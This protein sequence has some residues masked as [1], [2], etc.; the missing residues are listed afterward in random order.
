MANILSA[1]RIGVQL[2]GGS[3]YRRTRVSLQISVG[4]VLTGKLGGLIGMFVA[5]PPL[6]F[7]VLFAAALNP[8]PLIVGW[9]NTKKIILQNFAPVIVG[10]TKHQKQLMKEFDVEIDEIKRL[11]ATF[12]DKLVAE[13][14]TEMGTEAYNFQLDDHEISHAFEHWLEEADLT[15]LNDPAQKEKLKELLAKKIGI[16]PDDAHYLKVLEDS[17][18]AGD[19]FCELSE[20]MA[21]LKWKLEHRIDE[22]DAEAHH[23]AGGAE[24]DDDNSGAVSGAGAK[25]GAKA[26][27]G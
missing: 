27:N 22:L 2:E 21:K 12:I 5:N 7:P 4:N 15:K 13:L 26:N 18:R 10:I 24:D 19:S 14:K 16:Q 1:R 17:I 8:M 11:G 23:H 3:L 25:E 6:I 9:C 20:N